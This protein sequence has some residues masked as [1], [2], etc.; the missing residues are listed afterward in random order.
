M[1][2][3]ETT[4]IENINNS[5]DIPGYLLTYIQKMINTNDGS[6]I[7]P[8]GC[9]S[10]FL[11]TPYHVCCDG[12]RESIEISVFYEHRFA[13]Y[14]WMKWRREKCLKNNECLDS[15]DAPHLV[16]MDLH[17]DFGCDCDFIKEHIIELNKAKNLDEIALFT[18]LGLRSLNDGHILP[19]VWLNAVGD[20]YLVVEQMGQKEDNICVKDCFGNSHNIHY[21]KSL[22]EFAKRWERSDY[23]SQKRYIY[24]DI[25][26]DYFTKGDCYDGPIM[27]EKEIYEIFEKGKD[28]VRVILNAVSGITFALEPK[29]SRG[30]FTALNFYSI[31]EKIF[32]NGNLF[33]FGNCDWQSKYLQQLELKPRSVTVQR[34]GVK[35]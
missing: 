14:Y 24:W 9:Y 19:A 25:D 2:N 29:Y 33:P 11:K 32:L 7:N 35:D 30:I 17:N 1:Q 26:L 15:F 27:S 20:V 21:V 13:F 16:S 3:T 8:P 23:N 4:Q 28:G 5:P 10:N 6:Y 34:E 18:W 12:G 31:W 22:G